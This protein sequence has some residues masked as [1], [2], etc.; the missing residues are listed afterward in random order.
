MKVVNILFQMFRQTGNS[1]CKQRNLILRRTGICIMTPHI[2]CSVNL[3]SFRQHNIRT[4]VVYSHEHTTAD[5]SINY[6]VHY[7]RVFV[8]AQVTIPIHHFC[9][10]CIDNLIS[11]IIHCKKEM[12]GCWYSRLILHY[13]K[14]T[15]KVLIFLRHNALL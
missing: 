13:Q 14:P 5:V 10:S 12:P 2:A 15:N 9:H 4:T 6:N 3:L 8:I 11:F 1:A 7:T